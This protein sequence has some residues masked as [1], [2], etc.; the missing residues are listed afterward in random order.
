M[1][2]AIPEIC[3][4]GEGGFGVRCCCRPSALRAVLVR[5]SLCDLLHRRGRRGPGAVSVLM[6]QL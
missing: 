5:R 2:M 3:P 1:G 6:P 4:S